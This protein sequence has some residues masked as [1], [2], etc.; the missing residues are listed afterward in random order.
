MHNIQWHTTQLRSVFYKDIY[1]K[2]CTFFKPYP[3]QS[4]LS[5]VKIKKCKKSVRS[6]SSGIFF[7]TLLGNSINLID[8]SGGQTHTHTHTHTH[9]QCMPPPLSL[10][11]SHTHTHTQSLEN[12]QKDMVHHILPPSE[13]TAREWLEILHILS[14]QSEDPVITRS[15]SKGH[16][17]QQY[18]WVEC[19]L[20]LATA[21]C[22]GTFQTCRKTCKLKNYTSYMTVVH[23]LN[24]KTHFL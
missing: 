10:S 8:Y 21:C 16:H 6:K 2:L 11:L 1:I 24:T 12:K 7:Q 13:G 20:K 5:W 17:T 15:G 23:N 14:V 19:E 18:T 3:T 22:N 9:T 4:L